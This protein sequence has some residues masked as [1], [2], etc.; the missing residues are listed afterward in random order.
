MNA[1]D[2]EWIIEEEKLNFYVSFSKMGFFFNVRIFL[3]NV[4]IV[5]S[6]Y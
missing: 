3:L 5:Q 2:N 6:S 4:S 1:K